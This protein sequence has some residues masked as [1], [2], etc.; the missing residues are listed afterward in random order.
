MNAHLDCIA[1]AENKC[2]GILEPPGEVGNRETGVQSEI[3]IRDPHIHRN[4]HLVNVAMKTERAFHLDLRIARHL[5]APFNLAR[6]KSDLRIPLTPEYL[7]MHFLTAPAI[8]AFTAGRV[9]YEHCPG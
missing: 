4:Y 1:G 6:S 7:W 2:A 8:P 5:D 3:R 9:A